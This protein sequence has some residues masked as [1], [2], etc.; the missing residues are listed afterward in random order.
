MSN[1]KLV[2][3]TY[4]EDQSNR[5]DKF[6]TSNLTELSRSR[7]QKIIKGGLVQVD[8][9][10]IQK[11]G[12]TLEKGMEI[13]ISIPPI[14][15]LEI[16]PEPIPLNIIFEN[17][18]M[19]VVDKPAGMVVHPSAGHSEGTLVHA[20]LAHASEIEG[21]GGIRRPGIV[22]RLDK[23]TSGLIVIAKN[24]RT[25]LWLQNQFKERQ[26]K[27]VYLSLIDGEPPTPQGRIEA[28][29][30]RD[31]THRKKMM[32]TTPQRG[33]NAISEYKV[34]EKFPEHT[35]V[36]VHLHT[37]R[38]HQIRV[39]MAFLGC[40]VAG[41]RVYGR[42]NSTIPID[43]HFLHAYRLNLVIPGEATQRSFEAPLPEEL[44]QIL[45]QLR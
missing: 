16:K 1:H 20:V 35:L 3:L 30:G 37:G 36:E 23:E 43:R 11:T 22:H 26:V 7:L 19:L 25:H 18:D 45:A 33:K 34:I 4:Q 8:G 21:V 14:Q 32:V 5:L 6:L 40:P 39:H 44:K 38:T 17:Q 2:I 27:K 29:I 13:E 12:Y 9:D 42:R 15:A 28:A 24:D 10:I 31:S 41:D